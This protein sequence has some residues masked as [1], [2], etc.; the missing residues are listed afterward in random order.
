MNVQFPKQE[1]YAVDVMR[2]IFFHRRSMPSTFLGRHANNKKERIFTYKRDIVCLPSWYKEKM[3]GNCLPIPRGNESR[4]YLA[5]HGLLGKITLTSN[6]TEI[7]IFKEIS[8]V[9]TDSFGGRENF[10]F[11]ILQPTGGFS[12]SLTVPRISSQYKWSASSVAGKNAKVP[13]YILAQELLK[14]CSYVVMLMLF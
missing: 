7:Q 13:I 14:V 4:Q 3:S 1:Y 2:L 5:R 6:M 10:R 12:K 8:S 9:F 11:L